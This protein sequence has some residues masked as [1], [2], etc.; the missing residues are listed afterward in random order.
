MFFISTSLPFMLAVGIR[1]KIYSTLL[2]G[3]CSRREGFVYLKDP[4]ESC[5]SKRAMGWTNGAFWN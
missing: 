5:C 4:L 3:I 2:R 1:P